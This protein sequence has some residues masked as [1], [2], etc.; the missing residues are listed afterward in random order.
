MKE[1]IA[2]LNGSDLKGNV[3]FS[4]S[5]SITPTAM[6]DSR[7]VPEKLSL[8]AYP[9]LPELASASRSGNWK[10]P[11]RTLYSSSTFILVLGGGGG[12]ESTW[13]VGH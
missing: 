1:S 10:H 2:A 6:E 4:N 3:A 9:V 12:T 13:Y 7:T 11:V 5:V 8:R